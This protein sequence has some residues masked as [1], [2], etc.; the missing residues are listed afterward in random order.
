MT[1]FSTAECA[2]CTCERDEAIALPDPVSLT[3]ASPGS[4]NEAGSGASGSG[5]AGG[6]IG[7]A[8]VGIL[9]ALVL[10]VFVVKRHRQQTRSSPVPKASADDSPTVARLELLENSGTGVTP[11]YLNPVESLRSSTARSVLSFMNGTGTP[12]SN[13]RGAGVDAHE[14]KWTRGCRVVASSLHR[15]RNPGPCHPFPCTRPAPPAASRRH[16][17]PKMMSTFLTAP[18]QS[19]SATAPIFRQRRPSPAGAGAGGHVALFFSRL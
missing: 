4:E 16:G 17:F 18:R 19:R 5:G 8:V 11:V 10:L 7:G 9:L 1:W 15:S 14:A 12:S 3:T 13:V 6:A 2:G